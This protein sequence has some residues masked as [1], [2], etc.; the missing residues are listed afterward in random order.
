MK[1]TL[2]IFCTIMFIFSSNNVGANMLK[3][4]ENKHKTFLAAEEYYK[5]GEL[6]KYHEFNNA[7]FNLRKKLLYKNLEKVLKNESKNKINRELFY[8]LYANKHSQVSPNR[9][10][11]LFCTVMKTKNDTQYKFI[12]IDAETSEVIVEG[13]GIDYT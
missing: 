7:I 5:K 2:F 6:Y 9:Q 13:D 11:Y 10:V 4:P 3:Y 1:K 8:N 12:M